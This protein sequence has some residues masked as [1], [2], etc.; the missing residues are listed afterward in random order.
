MSSLDSGLEPLIGR[1]RLPRTKCD[2]V[3]EIKDGATH[4]HRAQ[5]SDL[6]AAGFRLARVGFVPS[7]NS[8]WLR[9]GETELLPAKVRWKAGQA[10]GC[11]FLY[12]LDKETHA[13]IQ[14]LVG[15]VSAE[16]RE[17]VSQS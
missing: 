10:V 2:W 14:Q 17:L 9:T 8:L 15:V 11:E 7:G 13:R 4:W 6:S 16:P 5:L 3:V 12:P 1:R